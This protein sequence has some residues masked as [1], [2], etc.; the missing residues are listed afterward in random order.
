MEKKWRKT[1][2]GEIEV[3]AQIGAGAGEGEVART[4]AGAGEGAGSGAVC[5]SDFPYPK[6]S[7]KVNNVSLTAHF[8]HLQKMRQM[9]LNLPFYY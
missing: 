9:C 7:L 5:K 4:G 6:Q 8:Q 1:S 2:E 3:R